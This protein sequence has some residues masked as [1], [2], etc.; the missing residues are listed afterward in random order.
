VL[1]D[2]SDEK[3]TVVL[4]HLAESMRKI[5][6][7]EPHLVPRLVLVE[8]FPDQAPGAGLFPTLI[9]IQMLLIGGVERSIDEWR[10]L[11]KA[12]GFKINSFTHT[13]SMLSVL[14]ASLE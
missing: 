3:V 10:V 7:K 4:K 14:E 8:F 12:N 11:L 1:H 6:A 5:P 9:D 13:R 2:W